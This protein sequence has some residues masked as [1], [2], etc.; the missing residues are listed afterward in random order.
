MSLLIESSQKSQYGTWIEVRL[1]R[2]RQNLEALKV[3]AGSSSQI[4]AVVKANAYGHGLREIAK[5]LSGQ[6][7]FLGISSLRE[8]LELKDQGVET[9]IFIFG[10]LLSDEMPAAIAQG[11]TLS[12]SSFEEAKEISDLSL[13]FSHQTPIHIKVDTGMGRL[14]IPFGH[15]L[16][17]VQKI[18]Q[19]DGLIMD[20]I[21]THFPIAEN[22]GLFTQ[23]QLNDFTHLIESLEEAGIHFRYRHA[24]NSAGTIHVRNSHLNLIRPGIM[25]YGIYPDASLQD[26]IRLAP[27]LSLK[28]RIIN[29]KRLRAGDSAGYGRDFI[30]KQPTTI[31]VLPTGYSHG[32]PFT[33]SNRAEVLF[34][35]KKYPLAGRVSMDYITINLGD[36]MARPGDEVTLIG[37]DRG[38]VILAE[39]LAR[40]ARTIPY[41]IVTRLLP[42]LPRLYH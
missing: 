14:G 42:S 35:G 3:H 33:A 8:A 39:D 38:Q 17:S 6:A 27:I 1:N 24:A 20:G 13:S 10:R 15:A 26:S 30:A 31:A 23:Q 28:S 36:D 2:L 37:E 25:L 32:Y 4:M 40:W 16:S 22:A 5:A 21:Y 34:N 12:V 7:A 9:P 19:L 41:E 29:V 11:F 18:S